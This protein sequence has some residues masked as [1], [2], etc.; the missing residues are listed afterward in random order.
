MNSGIRRDL[1]FLQLCFS[2]TRTYDILYEVQILSGA[3][4]IE[5]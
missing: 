1:H 4:E 5:Q 3:K 2:N